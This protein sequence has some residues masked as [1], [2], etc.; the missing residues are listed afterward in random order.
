MVANNNIVREYQDGMNFPVDALTYAAE[1]A[2]RRDFV[3][4]ARR[5]VRVWAHPPGPPPPPMLKPVSIGELMAKRRCDPFAEEEAMHKQRRRLRERY[6]VYGAGDAG[7]KTHHLGYRP[8][9]E[10]PAAR[11]RARQHAMAYVTNLWKELETSDLDIFDP[12]LLCPWLRAVEV[13][14]AKP[15]RRNRNAAPPRPLEVTPEFEHLEEVP[16]FEN[17]EPTAVP[18]LPPARENLIASAPPPPASRIRLTRVDQI[19]V[20]PPRWLLRGIL[21]RDTFALIFGD[22]GCGKSF[23]AI[24]W[25]CRIATGT[26]WRGHSVKSG[27][28]VYVAGE[29]Q[30]GFGR[31]IRAWSEHHNISLQNKPLFLAPS[32][33]IPEPTDLISL[34]TAIDTGIA[35]VGPPTLIVLDTLAR[36]FGGGDENSTQDMS[37]FVTACDA[38]RYRYDCTILVVHHSGHSD[39]S[40]ARGAIALKAALDAEYRLEN[41][42]ALL[43]TATKM[44]DAETPPPLAMKLAPVELPD[45]TDE[46]G[47]PVTS[48]VIEV[49]DADTSAIV[50]KS[51]TAM[52]GK[53]QKTGLEIAHR[54]AKHNGQVTME[55]WRAACTS[56]GMV[57]QNLH[58][59]LQVLADR[60]EIIVTGELLSIPN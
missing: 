35:T 17:D 10:V 20:H 54:L 18:S 13:W 8:G 51:K 15:L 56:A 22:P 1:R 39:K 43:L 4:E 57:R 27:P 21:E 9:H 5:I 47:N 19:E 23:L 37:K 48:A 26:P 42:N 55:A 29:G 50:A 45:L 58:R 38:I 14:A 52:S 44:K 11:L 12:K 30:Q 59:V 33:A 34:L 41:E 36:C 28:V 60:G 2:Y 31:R 7:P 49:L 16:E 6:T 3:E 25:A 24:D 53:W 32:V 40:R 46:D